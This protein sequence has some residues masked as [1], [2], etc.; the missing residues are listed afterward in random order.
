MSHDNGHVDLNMFTFD[1][2]PLNDAPHLPFTFKLHVYTA[3][4]ASNPQPFNWCLQLERAM[5]LIECMPLWMGDILIL[6]YDC[7]EEPLTDV[8]YTDVSLYHG[9]MQLTIVR[10][11]LG[12]Q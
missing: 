8:Y 11:R 3:C 1:R 6:K 7:N 9:F 5:S 2:L 10:G 12:E 4:Q